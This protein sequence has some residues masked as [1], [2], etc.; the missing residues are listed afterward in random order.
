M[1]IKTFLEVLPPMVV[2]FICI[3]IGFI[4]RKCRILPDN[5]N[6]VMSKL[7]NWVFC[8]ALSI[9]TFM[10]RCTVENISKH[11]SLVLY[12]IGAGVIAFFIAIFLAKIFVRQD[13]YERNAYKYALMIGNIGFMGDPVVLGLFGQDMLFLY[14]LFYLPLTILIYTWGISILIP[15]QKTEGGHDNPLKR[16]INAPFI[17]LLIGSL[18]G[19]TGLGDHMPTIANNVLSTCAACMSPVAMLLTGF[20]IGTYSVKRMLTAKKVY[21]AAIFR[22][23]VIPAV[24]V[25]LLYLV[26]ANE[27]VLICGFF[28]F[29]TPFGLNTVVFPLAYGGDPETGASM[30]MIS[31]TLC[32]VTIPLL[33]GLLSSVVDVSGFLI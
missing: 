5:A 30:A 21:V 25:S 18:L 9:S 10:T 16:L 22:L 20:T 33:F 11:Y 14:K 4:L 17:A 8:P 12:C 26:G 31:H 3:A 23:V 28:A 15:K 24:L 27:I 13:C 7:E 29:A 6:T 19:L 1:I 2:L 32:I